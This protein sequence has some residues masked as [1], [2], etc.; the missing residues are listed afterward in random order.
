MSQNRSRA[1]LA[2]SYSREPV[3]RRDRGRGL[4]CT[5]GT[6]A[7]ARGRAQALPSSDTRLDEPAVS[8][9][10]IIQSFITD[11]GLPPRTGEVGGVGR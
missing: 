5:A 4:R 2:G 6:P 3:T 1:C 9:L 7:A 11:S 8:L 10:R